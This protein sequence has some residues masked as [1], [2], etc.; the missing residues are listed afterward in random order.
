MT[1]IQP[2]LVLSSLPL[3]TLAAFVS[4]EHFLNS[5]VPSTVEWPVDVYV[6]ERRRRIQAL[7][8]RPIRTRPVEP[9][10]ERE[11]AHESRSDS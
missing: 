8:D 9:P 3:L 7:N 5:R 11:N 6:Q 1:A 4:L 2:A 10:H